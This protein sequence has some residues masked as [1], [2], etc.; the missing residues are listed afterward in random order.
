[1][2]SKAQ[3]ITEFVVLFSVLSLAAM[4][5]SLYFRRGIQ[6]LIKV[7]SDEIGN[8]SD[9]FDT[10]YRPGSGIWKVQSVEARSRSSGSENTTKQVG[11]SER[12]DKTQTSNTTYE[13]DLLSGE[14]W[15][16]E[17]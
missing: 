15:Y 5:M 1:M 12:H 16:Y 14:L 9:A 8:Q 2:K 11:G 10:D 3:N 6:G 17:E 4:S 7:A 13:D